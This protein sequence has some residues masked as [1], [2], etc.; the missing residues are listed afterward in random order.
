MPGLPSV[1]RDLADVPVADVIHIS[2]RMHYLG[3]ALLPWV[4]FVNLIYIGP[5]ARKNEEV[6]KGVKTCT[7]SCSFL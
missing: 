4:W 5:V 2:Q 7:R 6:M 3:F 1:G